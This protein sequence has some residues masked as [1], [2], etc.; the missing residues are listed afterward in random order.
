MCLLPCR[1]FGGV[2]LKTTT[3][4]CVFPFPFL[5]VRCLLCC[6]LFCRFCVLLYI[7]IVCFVVVMFFLSGSFPCIACGVVALLFRFVCVS[8]LCRVFVCTQVV[9]FVGHLSI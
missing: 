3:S 2:H 4:V 5:C 7:Y 1:V 9:L 6:G 8:R